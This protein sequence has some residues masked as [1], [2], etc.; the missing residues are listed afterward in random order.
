MSYL[1][2]QILRWSDKTPIEVECDLCHSIFKLRYKSAQRNL[3]KY[4]KHKCLPC[5]GQPLRPQ[6]T[7]EY[8]TSGR[9]KSLSKSISCS[10]KYRKSIEK[11]DI[12]G[13]NNGMYGKKHDE[14]SR[15]KMSLSR[16]GKIGENATAWKGGKSSLIRRL[17][18]MIHRRF[19]WYKKVYEKNR[20]KCSECGTKKHL[21]AHHVKP[22]SKIVKDL[23]EGKQFNN[24]NEKLLWLIKQPEIQDTDLKNGITLC[25]KHHKRIHNNWGSHVPS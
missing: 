10:K 17:K 16:T 23:C 2:N 9:R 6:C 18:E 8:W 13:E 4:N 1:P 5:T 20:W 7:S 25:R 15:K 14:L 22:I 3:K 11:R 24:D 19:N 21:D 12:A